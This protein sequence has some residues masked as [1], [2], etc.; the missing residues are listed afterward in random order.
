ML[1]ATTQQPSH[2]SL[3]KPGHQSWLIKTIITALTLFFANSVFA[4]SISE[5]R[6]LLARTGFSPS[7]TEIQQYRHLNRQQ[8]IQKRIDSIETQSQTFLDDKFQL[9]LHLNIN[10]KKASQ[11][12]KKAFRKELRKQSNE[13]KLW[14]LNEMLK[15][16]SPFTENLTLFWHNHFV[17]SSQKVKHPALMAKQNQTLRKY[18]AGN[19]RDFLK[20]MLKDPALLR[21]LDNP[22]NRKGKLNENLG[23]ELLELFTLSEGHYSE[24]DIKNAAKALTGNSIDRKTGQFK[25]YRRAHDASSK[26]ILGK[27]G[28]WDADDLANIILQQKQTAHFVTE[29]LWNHFITT[30]IPERRLNQLSNAFYGGYE[31]KPLIQ[32][33][34]SQPEFWSPENQGTKIKAPINLLVGLFR[35]FEYQPKN[36]KQL[37]KASIA[38][39]QNLL[40]PPNVKGWNT[41]TGWINTTTLLARQNFIANATRGMQIRK[42]VDRQK[43]NNQAWLNALI[44]EPLQNKISQE[45]STWK[46]V[47]NALN[48]ISFQLE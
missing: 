1:F 43:Q 11:S 32:N 28:N 21:Y 27:T 29:K 33:I 30:K 8:S 35:Q 47:K 41:G 46:T 24:Q 45:S 20:A 19:F 3:Y 12:E 31:I 6:H 15:T 34:L 14:W 37:V 22:K 40:A 7:F 39:G 48:H 23:R 10:L 5:S 26:T 17:S 16:E 9:P 25:F 42:L 2:T 4:L 38:M 44:A 36:P 13:L 18:A